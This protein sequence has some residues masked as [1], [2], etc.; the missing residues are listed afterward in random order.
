MPVMK[1]YHEYASE[2]LEGKFSR[3]GT[4]PLIL[5]YLMNKKTLDVGCSDGLYLQDL[6][7]SSMGIEQMP[8]LA[9]MGRERGLN[10]IKGDV[11][12]VLK[13]LPRGSFEAV[14]FSHVMEHM[15]NPIASLRLINRVLVYGGALILG[16]PLEHCCVRDIKKNYFGGTH[17]YSF[18]IRNA[19]QLLSITGFRNRSV[20]YQLPK[21]DCLFSDKINKIWNT[22]PF[23]LKGYF[24]GSYWIIAEKNSDAMVSNDL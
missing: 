9:D 4:W 6:S 13:G 21:G 22:L 16:L 18:S 2:R 5:P 19:K 15:E 23:P 24:S 17:L 3:M 1:A 11:M 10:V 7:P 14:L 20:I 12:T 8:R